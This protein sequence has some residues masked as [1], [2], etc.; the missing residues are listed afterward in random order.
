[1]DLETSLA[2]YCQSFDARHGL[3]QGDGLR[4]ARM[5]IQERSLMVNLESKDLKLKEGGGR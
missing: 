4:V 2:D 5:L 3:E 1:M